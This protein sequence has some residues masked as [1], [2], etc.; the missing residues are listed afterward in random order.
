[1][2]TFKTVLL[3][4]ALSAGL[5]LPVAA[6]PSGSPGDELFA[7]TSA[8]L[9]NRDSHARLPQVLLIRG[10]QGIVGGKVGLI[11]W[12]GSM[13][14]CLNHNDL[15]LTLPVRIED[16]KVGD[17]IAYRGETQGQAAQIVH[18][19]IAKEADGLRVKGDANDSPDA[20]LITPQILLGRVRYVVQSDTHQIRDF[21]VDPV[22][23]AYTTLR[24]LTANPPADIDRSYREVL[25]IEQ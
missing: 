14:P 15:I 5:C 13:V 3:T 21:S 25:Y 11:T 23:G 10:L 19:V 24:A 2:P 6:N 1:V 17:I 20:L 12:T 8:Q 9:Q 7:L 22:N 18:R 4:A 16:V